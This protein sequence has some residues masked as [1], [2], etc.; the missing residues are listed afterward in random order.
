MKASKNT[1]PFVKIILS[2]A[3][4]VIV[5]FS[6]LSHLL[7][8]RFWHRSIWVQ[9]VMLAC[10][11][12][13]IGYLF[14]LLLSSSLMGRFSKYSTA[15]LVVWG[16]MA[17]IT[18]TILVLLIDIPAGEPP[19][20]NLALVIIATGENN[21][22]AKGSRVEITEIKQDGR[23][24]DF[25]ALEISGDW[26]KNSEGL[27]FESPEPAELRY[28]FPADIEE[29]KIL[30]TRSPEAGIVLVRL[31]NRQ[32]HIDLFD[33]E[34]GYKQFSITSPTWPTAPAR[35]MIDGFVSL[36]DALLIAIIVFIASGRLVPEIA[37]K[38]F[39]DLL[40]RRG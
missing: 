37:M 3:V 28:E 13:V 8:L 10:G 21:A 40:S 39:R 2:M 6:T 27:I 16:L 17:L 35:R 33:D 32:H 36:A 12:L 34:T 30:F 31:N 25:D 22:Q 7:P 20:P 4:G 26:H 5:S 9:A 19:A 14:N 24:L 1:R 23:F 15:V 29:F 11:T 38:K 18:G